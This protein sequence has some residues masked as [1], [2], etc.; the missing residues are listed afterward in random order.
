EIMLQQTQVRTVIP[1]WERWMQA[2]PDVPALARAPEERV[3]KLWEG[4]GYYSRA[5]NLQRAARLLVERGA[6]VPDTVEG[7]LELP[8]IGRYTAGAIAS[9]AFL[10]PAP[11]LDGNVIRVLTR[12]FALGGDPKA[13]RLN[14]R[15]WTLAEDLVEAAASTADPLACS[16]SNQGLMELGALICTPKDP[17]CG[18]CPLEPHCRGRALGR[19]PRLPGGSRRATA[20]P[21]RRVVVVAEHRGRRWVRQRPADAVNGGFWEFPER[22]LAEGSE[23]LQVAADWLGTS[24]SRFEALGQVRHAI[25]RHRILLD[26][27]RLRGAPRRGAAMSARWVSPQQLAALPLTGA[28]RRIAR[29]FLGRSAAT[30]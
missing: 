17:C 6:A 15:L 21:L 11:I 14:A 2:L 20:V 16:A 25:T 13:S 27:L 19:V 18:E 12:L 24:P 29:R 10:R 3:L 26:V 1:Y 30:R 23:A 5:R 4:L 9:I 8:G 28:H 7:L 22:D